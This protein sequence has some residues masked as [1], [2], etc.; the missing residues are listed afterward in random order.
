MEERAY[1][2]WTKDADGVR[3]ITFANR[4]K[5]NAL[6]E[7]LLERLRAAFDVPERG[8][9]RAFLLE[10][11][12]E[13][14]GPFCAGYDLSSLVEAGADG[15]LPD[16]NL[17]AVLASIA[18]HPVPS[19]VCLTGAAYG[20]GCDLASACDFRVGSASALFVMPPA[21]LGV[22]YAEQ[23]LAR[24]ARHLGFTRAKYL[25]LTGRRLDSEG[26]ER[27]GLLDERHPTDAQARAAALALARELAAQ[28]PLAVGGMKRAF[29]ALA[30][31]AL[32]DA[33]RAQLALARREAYLSAD[34]REGRDAFRERRA[35]RFLG[36]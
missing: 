32:S 4:R 17:A 7:P 10:A 23:G 3:T 5:K 22:V 11:E 26:A 28:A 27:W 18:R 1:G 33:V 14:G 15:P 29:E 12:A 6:D 36:R 21:R 13:E 30:E 31:V 8:E 35:P 20:A 16:D 24:M 9:V 2:V 34:A 25:F 19:V